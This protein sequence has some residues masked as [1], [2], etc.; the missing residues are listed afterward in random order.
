MRTKFAAAKVGKRKVVFR[1]NLLE[2][3]LEQKFQNKSCQ[4]KSYQNN[5]CL[6]T[7]YLNESSTIKCCQRKKLL[8]Q[9]LLE[10][11]LLEKKASKK[12]HQDKSCQTKSCQDKIHHALGRSTMVNV[13]PFKLK[14]FHTLMRFLAIYQSHTLRQNKLERLLLTTVRSQ[15]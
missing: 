4:N 3:V 13:C 8:D 12:C 9:K 2:Q 11:N 6:N 14:I 1:P 10:Q 5:S 15:V 7:S